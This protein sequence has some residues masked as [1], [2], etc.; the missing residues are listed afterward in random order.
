MSTDPKESYSRNLSEFDEK[1]EI[2]IVKYGDSDC[3]ERKG[4]TRVSAIKTIG[5]DSDDDADSNSE[6]PTPDV[7]N[8]DH[9]ICYS[10]LLELRR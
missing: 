2:L 10:E 4:T 6:P 9:K 1:N 5:F 7:R 3:E 8:M